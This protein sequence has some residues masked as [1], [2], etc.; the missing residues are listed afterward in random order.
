MDEDAWKN[1][2]DDW[3][4]SEP[5][6]TGGGSRITRTSWLAA[7]RRWGC[8][9]RVTATA[10]DGTTIV[11]RRLSAEYARVR[12]QQLASRGF[13]TEIADDADDADELAR[14]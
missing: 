13:G 2:Y 1:H 7:M 3:K 14:P 10:P 4:T 12:A 9:F 6:E 8:T 11:H 5:P